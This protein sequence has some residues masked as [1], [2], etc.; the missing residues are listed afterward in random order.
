MGNWMTSMFGGRD[1]SSEQ[2]D[3]YFTQGMGHLKAGRWVSSMLNHSSRTMI[4]PSLFRLEEAYVCANEALMQDPKN[5]RA[6]TLLS[7]SFYTLCPKM[8]RV[9]MA[10][11]LCDTAAASSI[12]LDHT[13][14]H[15]AITQATKWHKSVA[16]LLRR[17]L[18]HHTMER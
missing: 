11:R 15:A 7:H 2:A 3:G 17:A 4:K 18:Y 8:R 5:H 10:H 13:T 12:N 14:A 16:T 6:V 9:D 1:G